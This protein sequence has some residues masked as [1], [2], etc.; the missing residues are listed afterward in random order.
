MLAVLTALP[1]LDIYR[2]V[3]AA[4]EAEG[5]RVTMLD[6]TRAVARAWPPAVWQDGTEVPLA[7]IEAVLPRIGNWRPESAL[8]VLEALEAGGAVAL[9]TAAAVRRGRDH[10]LTLHALAAAGLPHPATVAGCEPEVLAREAARVVGFPC[11]VKQRRSR[12]GVGVIRCADRGALEAVLDSLW[13][14]GDEFVVQRFCLP[15]GISRR[16]LVLEGMV[17]GAMEHHAAKREFR[18][19]AA[20]GGSVAMVEASAEE[21]DLASAAAA[22]VGLGLAGVDLFPEDGRWVV[23]EVNPTPGWKH[24]A[25]ATAVPVATLVVRALAARTVRR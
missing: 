6:A 8:A 4:A 16:L 20:R 17:L 21:R 5:I 25:A 18:T 23:G 3:T 24:F 22:V 10:W 19:N 12:Q 14:V 2:E 9:N 15:G 13:R 7:S 11:V 1:E